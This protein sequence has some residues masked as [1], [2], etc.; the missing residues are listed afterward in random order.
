MVL[1]APGTDTNAGSTEPAGGL[2]NSLSRMVSVALVGLPGIRPNG[3]TKLKSERLT[4]RLALVTSLSNSG[5]AKVR[6]LMFAAKFSVL[7]VP[8]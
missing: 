4:T 6:L 1:S 7:L 2:V 3:P 5:T 8:R